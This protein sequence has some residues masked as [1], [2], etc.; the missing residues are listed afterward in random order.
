MRSFYEI[1]LQ[2][3]RVMLLEDS[4]I[5]LCMR[6][7]PFVLSEISGGHRGHVALYRKSVS[8]RQYVLFS[9]QGL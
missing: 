1:H 2:C 9:T 8:A 4:R 3:P 7:A 6:V 5:N